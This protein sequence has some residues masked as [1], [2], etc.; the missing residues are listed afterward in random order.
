MDAK[1]QT[2]DCVG[3]ESS[4]ELV[5]TDAAPPAFPDQECRRDLE[6]ALTSEECIAKAS[7]I[8]DSQRRIESLEEERKSSMKRY[9]AEIEEETERR[10]ALIDV[11]TRG[12]E[13]RSVPRV[14]LNF[15]KTGFKEISRLDTNEVVEIE[16][17]TTADLD[18]DLPGI[19]DGGKAEA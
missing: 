7:E 12:T 5:L 11:F 13:H 15:P 17:M 1:T 9:A 16:E 8:V 2:C 4:T 18:Q 3:E 19:D 6:C 10:D 14:R